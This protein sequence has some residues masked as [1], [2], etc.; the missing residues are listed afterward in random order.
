[1]ATND[2]KAVIATYDIKPDAVGLSLTQWAFQHSGLPPYQWPKRDIYL[3]HEAKPVE[4]A[5]MAVARDPASFVAGH[6]NLYLWSSLTGNGK[7]TWAIRILQE[8]LVAT[9]GYS[10]YE[11]IGYFINVPTFL[12]QLQESYNDDD[13]ADALQEPKQAMQHCPLVVFDDIASTRLTENEQKY[14]LSFIDQ[15]VLNGQSS[16]YTGNCG[17][18]EL[19]AYVGKRLKSRVYNGAERIE[20]KSNDKR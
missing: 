11:P 18:A 19:D 5:L 1:M 16:I 4:D 14:L 2:F 10:A 13:V 15:R 17:E 12:R 3:G 7:T 9:A 8:Y 6:K 20:F